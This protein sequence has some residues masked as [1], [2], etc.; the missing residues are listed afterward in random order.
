MN[1]YPFRLTH[2]SFCC[3][4][5]LVLNPYQ[6]R[7]FLVPSSFGSRS[8]LVQFSFD[9]RFILVQSILDPYSAI[10][11]SDTLSDIVASG[12]SALCNFCIPLLFRGT[13]SYGGHSV[14]QNCE[15]PIFVQ[16][17]V[18]LYTVIGSVRH[19]VD[20]RSVRFIRLVRF[21]HPASF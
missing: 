8:I 12:L 1:T 9:S 19:S 17:G 15:Y 6:F 21:L 5:I 13:S 2:F 3:R 11:E 18:G 7:P 4:S 16:L 10:V 20:H 14:G